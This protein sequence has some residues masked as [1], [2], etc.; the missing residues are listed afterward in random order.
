MG[1]WHHYGPYCGWPPP[2]EWA[3]VYRR[4]RWVVPWEPDEERHEE[5]EQRRRRGSRRDLD[6]RDEEIWLQTLE[7][8][9]RELRQELE[10]I[11]SDI[12][13][14]APRPDEDGRS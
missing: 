4:H 14:L 1:C 8:R 6:D 11:E 9:A 3:D 10:R 7:S 2:P 5:L 13:R 12:D